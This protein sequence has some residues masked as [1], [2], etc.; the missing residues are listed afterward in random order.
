MVQ[1]A[2]VK[3]KAVLIAPEA[4]YK[5]V[6]QDDGL[7]RL[8]KLVDLTIGEAGLADAEILMSTWGAPVLDE[9]FL[10]K[11]PNLKIV[12]YAAGTV[13]Y[14]VTDAVWKRG[15]KI[16]SSWAANAVPVAEFTVAQIILGLKNFFTS[17]R[18]TREARRFR[19]AEMNGIYKRKIGLIGIGMIGRL[20]REMLKQYELEVLACDPYLSDEEAERIGVK[21]VPLEEMF[22]ICY[23]VSLHAPNIPETR[24]MI[25]GRHIESMPQNACFINTSRGA[26]VHEGELAEALR[27][28]KDITCLLDVTDPEPPLTD[29]ELWDIPNLIISPHIAG[30]QGD[31]CRRLAAYSIDELERYLK[32][33]PLKY[34]V[35]EEMLPR[36]A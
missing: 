32:D 10:A 20:V 23:V 21:K 30:S 22:R 19:M 1:L 8:S 26:L 34:L 13:K 7:E 2:T 9:E 4:N 18:N 15:I 33:E 16:Q 25:R 14:F 35:T 11:A 36:M 6:Y 12:F 29:S 5:K 31:E 3:K 17:V 28:R 24:H 27:T